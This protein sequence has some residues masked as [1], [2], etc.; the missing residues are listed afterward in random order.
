MH[1]AESCLWAE[2]EDEDCTQDDAAAAEQQ[3]ALAPEDAE[4]QEDEQQWRAGGNDDDETQP[5]ERGA[6]AAAE[7]DDEEDGEAA[8]PQTPPALSQEG[9]IDDQLLGAEGFEEQALVENDVP[10]EVI[11]QRI[12][13]LTEACILACRLTLYSVASARILFLF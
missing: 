10:G 3:H 11:L 4:T 8:R 7:D 13:K 1:A 5:E 9:R 12:E 6:Q 2:E